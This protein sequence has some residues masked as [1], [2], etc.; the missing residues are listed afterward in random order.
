[1]FVGRRRPNGA[2]PSFICAVL[3]IP[4]DVW[5]GWPDVHAVLYPQPHQ[6]SKYYAGHVVDV[7]IALAVMPVAMI[8]AGLFA[9]PLRYRRT[10]T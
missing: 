6:L 7:F 3:Q 5:F 4:V 2:A 10:S 1:L 9:A 8:I